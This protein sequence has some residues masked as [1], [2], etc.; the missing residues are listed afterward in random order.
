MNNRLAAISPELEN[1]LNFGSLPPARHDVSQIRLETVHVAIRDGTR[2]ATDLYLPPV[3]PAP[4]VAVRTPYDRARDDRGF[5]AT[6]LAFARRGYVVVSQDVRGT[7]GSEPDSWSYYMFEAED[8]YDC[9]EWI[10]KQPWFG[11]FIGSCGGSYVGQTQWCMAT[12][13]AMSTLIPNVSGLG[14]GYST[15][16]LYMFLNAYA[17][18]VGK[19]AAKVALRMNEMERYYEKETMAGGYFDEPLHKPFSEALLARFPELRG[20]PPSKAKRWLWERYS[21]MTCVERAEFIKQARGV[22]NVSSVDVE[23]MTEV[24]GHRISHDAFT[25]PHPSPPDLCRLINAPPLMRTGWYDWCLNDALATFE[26]F[27]R[28]AKPEVAA[29]ARLLITPYA[30]NV[31]GY[32]E[33]MDTHSELWRGQASML[34]FAGLMMRWYETVCDGATDA[35]PVV[36]Y[37]LMGA[38][39]WRTASDWPPP[40]AKTKSFYLASGGTLTTEPPRQPSQPDSYIYDPRDPT[41]TVGG[42]IVSF[43]YP[44][45]SV[46]VAAVQQRAD[47]LIYTTPPLERDL[48][49]VGPLKMVLYANS[50]ATDTDFVARLSDVF[51]D[52]RAI[53]LQSGILRARY[54]N[55]DGE[56]ALLEPGRVYRLEIDMLAT[57]NR[58]KAGHRL[59]VDIS[60][61]DF[62]HFDRNSNRGGEP[63]DPIPARQTIYHDAERPSQ[64]IVSVG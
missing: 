54:R 59:R 14:I 56:P 46:D 18:T 24:F 60:S 42:S 33:G 1:L 55:P 35:W 15:A 19:G 6:L 16:H 17:R 22:E 57:A 32:H 50:S 43:L 10:T 29:R 38:N 47:V 28:E 21:A 48:D 3:L 23:S 8:G 2:L 26:T 4:V 25:I 51:P 45:G 49:V 58:F 62:P 9:V 31:P 11:G 7:G 27:R 12:H 52:G 64:L 44:P 63:G 34:D 40:E 5:V 39:E 41:P 37:Y 20:M 61:A 13:P 53:Q 36:I 30:H